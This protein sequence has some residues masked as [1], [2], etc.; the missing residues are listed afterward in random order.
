MNWQE[1]VT[2]VASLVTMLVAVGLYGRQSRALDWQRRNLIDSHAHQVTA[3]ADPMP[4]DHP[5]TADGSLWYRVT[6]ENSGDEAVYGVRI[7]TLGVG[8]DARAYG[9][10]LAVLP[11]RSRHETSVLKPP[12]VS[13]PSF[14]LSFMDSRRNQWVRRD[15]GGLD[16]VRFPADGSGL[17]VETEGRRRPRRAGDIRQ[18]EERPPETY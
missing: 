6:I 14:E 2:V 3:W 7:V 16:K 12:H 5:P 13:M 8:D 18:K 11:A 9:S 15:K 4:S 10:P 17:I 1:M